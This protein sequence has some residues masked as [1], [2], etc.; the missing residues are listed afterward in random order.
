MRSLLIFIAILLAYTKS[1][2]IRS[3]EGDNQKGRGSAE[4]PNSY[5]VQVV[6]AGVIIPASNITVYFF[7][8]SAKLKPYFNPSVA[9][10]NSSGYASTRVTLGYSPGNGVIYASLTPKNFV[11]ANPTVNPIIQTNFTFQAEFWV[12]PNAW[13]QISVVLFMSLLCVVCSFGL[14]IY[15]LSKDRGTPNMIEVADAIQRGAQGFLKVQYTTIAFIAV[16]VGFILFLMYGY[17]TKTNFD[18]N[19]TMNLNATIVTLSFMFGA[20]LSGLSGFIGM[21]VSVRANSRVTSAATRSYSEAMNIATRAGAF[22]GF[23]V[24]SLSVFGVCLCFVILYGAMTPFIAEPQQIVTMIVGF[25][26]GCSLSALFAQLGGGIFTKAADVGA[27]LVGKVESDMPE[28]DLHNPAVI[29]DLVGD[30]VGDCAGRGSD[31][32]ESISAE[33]IGVMI[34]AASMAANAY[35]QISSPVSYIVF[36]LLVH[37]CGLIGSWIGI[38]FVR[39][40]S[41][42]TRHSGREDYML[43]VQ[44][45]DREQELIQHDDYN[46]MIENEPIIIGRTQEID[47]YETEELDDPMTALNVGYAVA[48][49]VTTALF[50]PICYWCLYTPEYSQ[51]WVRFLFCGL[52]GIATSW[53]F[54][55]ITVYYTDST[56]RP[57]LS[58]VEA[59]NTGHATNV[60]AGLAVGMESTAAPVVVIVLAILCSYYLGTTAGIYDVDGSNIGGL[61]GTA[62]ATIGM[63]STSSYVLTMDTLGPIVDNAGGIAEM[64]NEPPQVRAITDKLDAVGNTTKAL[65]KGYAIGSAALAS[66]LLFSAFLDTVTAYSGVVF[67]VVN[68]ASPEVFVGGLLGAGLVFLFTS[69]TIRAVNTAAQAV[70]EEVR[71]QF[72]ENPNLKNKNSP[73][74][75]DYE[76]C[77]RMITSSSLVQ[78]IA[79]GLLAVIVPIIVGFTFRYIGFRTNQLYLGAEVSAGLLMVATIVGILMAL[80]LNNAGGAWDNAKKYVEMNAE[81]LKRRNKSDYA[82]L[83]K[84]V[85]TGDTIGDPCK[86]TAGPSIHVLIKLLA[87][88]TLVVGP[89]FLNK[90]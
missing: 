64:S 89:L 54:V 72:R 87:T 23:L 84:S 49:I 15:V 88:I 30:N 76:R 45:N 2:L 46:P 38:F 81:M 24:V 82:E 52:V 55:F 58:I 71:R 79:P 44:S 39:V 78:M 7:T 77:V 59:S 61:F 13:A 32:F 18:P 50:I 6:R 8:N 33:N 9:I 53:A 63:L 27:D 40:K 34:L 20:F 5:V 66:F 65:T 67:S 4:L 16:P 51:A 85:V 86:D 12:N 37:I 1:Y 80:F 57:V 90:A 60:I 35:P 25:S 75:P 69:L 19:I 31:L 14:A 70:I 36:P 68:L 43:I 17:R 42:N 73:D 22:V 26:F 48:T 3:V 11:P 28:D 62:V 74:R 47:T 29:A 83:K 41:S 21:F 10:T 56:W